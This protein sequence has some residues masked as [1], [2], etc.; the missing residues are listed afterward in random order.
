MTWVT[1]RFGICHFFLFIDRIFEGV[2]NI[3]NPISPDKL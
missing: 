2:N 1:S 3:F